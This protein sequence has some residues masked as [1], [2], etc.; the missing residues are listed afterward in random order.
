MFYFKELA[1]Y[2]RRVFRPTICLRPA[3]MIRSSQIEVGT[4]LQEA[5]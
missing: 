2:R 1:L 4:E 5:W 3:A